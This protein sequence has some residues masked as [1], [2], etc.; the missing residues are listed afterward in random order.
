MDIERSLKHRP[1]VSIIDIANILASHANT[2][3][4]DFYTPN[5]GRLAAA[6]DE[7]IEAAQQGQQMLEGSF[8]DEQNVLHAVC[9]DQEY[10]PTTGSN[11][12]YAL[13]DWFL[14]G[15]VKKPKEI[16]RNISLLGGVA[17]IV[18]SQVVEQLFSTFKKDLYFLN[19]MTPVVHLF[20]FRLLCHFFDQVRCF[21]LLKQ[22]AISNV[23]RN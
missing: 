1:N 14:Q 3:V 5:E 7:N 15:N 19:N 22:L 17:G 2:T 16:L 4:P 23:S 20:I 13:F 10:N 18:D 12:H 9:H 6:T 21:D 8:L 11:L